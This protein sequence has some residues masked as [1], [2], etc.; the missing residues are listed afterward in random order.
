MASQVVIVREKVYPLSNTTVEKKKKSYL[1]IVS[2][3][4]LVQEIGNILQAKLH[5]FER[6]RAEYKEKIKLLSQQIES[7]SAI[8][9]EKPDLVRSCSFP[10]LRN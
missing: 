10:S 1:C 9:G 5:A 8:L 6:L 4:A 7:L 3:E 2:G